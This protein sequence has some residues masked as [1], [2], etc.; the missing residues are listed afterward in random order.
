[1]AA[2]TLGGGFKLLENILSVL[3]VFE[4]TYAPLRFPVNSVLTQ[5]YKYLR[6]QK[7]TSHSTSTT[8]KQSLRNNY[9]EQKGVVGR[10]QFTKLAK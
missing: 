2:A 6:L 7:K 3:R 10:I 9:R 4:L 8:E 1:M 5:N